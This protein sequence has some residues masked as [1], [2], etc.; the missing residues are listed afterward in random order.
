MRDLKIFPAASPEGP[1]ATEPIGIVSQ[2]IGWDPLSRQIHSWAFSADGGHGEAVWSR[3]DDAWVARSTS[4]HPDGRLTSSMNIYTYDGKDE[5]TWQSFQTYAGG[6]L[7]P[8]ITMTMVR[9]TGS[10]SR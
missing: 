4:V 7:A 8:P 1:P 10:S 3:E 2:R 9:T 5:C 6:D